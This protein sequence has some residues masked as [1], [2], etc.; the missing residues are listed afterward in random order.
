M[1]LK[2]ALETPNGLNFMAA[3]L[4]ITSLSDSRS[5]NYNYQVAPRGNVNAAAGPVKYN[6]AVN[7]APQRYSQYQVSVFASE[8]LLRGGQPAAAILNN[9]ATGQPAFQFSMDD[10]SGLERI[11]QAYADLATKFPDSEIIDV[12]DLGLV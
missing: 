11:E 6:A 9:D 5:D 3:V 1:A 7:D 4:V 8:E 12:G 10:T 2:T